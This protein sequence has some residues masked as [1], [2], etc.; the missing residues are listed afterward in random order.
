MRFANPTPDELRGAV[1]AGLVVVEVLLVCFACLQVYMLGRPPKRSRAV[2]EQKI[3]PAPDFAP[4][5]P[6][7]HAA[8]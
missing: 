2:A 5:P 7:A 4:A 8:R 1:L 6:A 3:R